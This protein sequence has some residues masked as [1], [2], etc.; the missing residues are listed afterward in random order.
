MVSGG[1]HSGC[2]CRRVSM[3]NAFEILGRNFY[4]FIYFW[5]TMQSPQENLS[6]SVLYTSVRFYISELIDTEIFLGPDLWGL[7]SPLSHQLI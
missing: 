4:L 3:T 2:K 6:I 7:V 5:F 1:K